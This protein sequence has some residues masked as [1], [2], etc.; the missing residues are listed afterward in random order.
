MVSQTNA[1]TYTSG[2]GA[3][4]AV[5]SNYSA[6]VITNADFIV[7]LAPLGITV[8]GTYSG[9]TTI[10]PTAFTTS[11]LV[12]AETIT[13]LSGAILNS[14]NVS[15][16][17]TNYVASFVSSGGTAA[18]SNYVITPAYNAT[19][20]TTTTNTAT[21]NK[22][23]LVVTETASLTGNL[24][25]GSA[26]TGTYT[27]TLLGAD[28]ATI[29][30]M[31]TG[32]NAATYTSDLVVAGAALSNYNTPVITNADLVVSPAPLV[33][34]INNATKVY[35]TTANLGTTAFTSTGLVNGEEISNVILTSPGTVSTASIAGSPYIITTS[36][37]PTGRGGFLASNY[38][39]SDIDGALSVTPVSN[40]IP[41]PLNN[42]MIEQTQNSIESS[43]CPNKNDVH[44]GGVGYA[45]CDKSDI[46]ALDFSENSS[47][48][49][50]SSA[51][52]L[53]LA[54]D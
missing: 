38:S 49:L 29:T 27:T 18:L 42:M 25:K 53:N 17:G 12:N 34:T 6:P 41:S 30:G 43:V 47:L 46:E 39:I 35:G 16:N 26:Y 24:Y 32:T 4:G 50:Q 19:P 1:G 52:H 51:L 8:V 13:A 14:A 40:L 23:D 7:R 11:G 37:P 48:K 5:L 36:S 31:A 20:S 3:T 22:A 15:A 9:S 54:I 2:L 21:L 45:P 33:I 44:I 10:A 28:S